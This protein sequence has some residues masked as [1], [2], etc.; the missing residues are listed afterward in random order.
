MK[1][2]KAGQLKLSFGMIFSII[3]IIIFLSFAFYAI[4]K[5][6]SISNSV[7]AGKF[8]DDFQSDVNKIWKSSQ[9]SQEFEYILPSK[10]EEICF[11]DYSS[12]SR[13]NEIIYD[14]L[15]VLYYEKEN[16][17]FYPIGSSGGTN[18]LEIEHLNI[19]KITENENPFCIDTE[20]GKV[21]MT[22]KKNYDET[23]VNISG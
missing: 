11:I 8:S 7:K 3:L 13:G 21:K 16:L 19:E 2:S 5:F 17:F 1:K 6:L 20:E 4:G 15:R 12:D 18:A 10:T 14:N 9:A 22:L 23:L